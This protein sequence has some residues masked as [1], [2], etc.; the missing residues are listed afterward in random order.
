MKYALQQHITVI[1]VL[2]LTQNLVLLQ[3]INC[4]TH[5]FGI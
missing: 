4:L 1:A 3:K 5:S 2:C